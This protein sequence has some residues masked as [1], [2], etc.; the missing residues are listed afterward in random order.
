MT[1]IGKWKP[2]WSSR[3]DSKFSGNI[4]NIS[5]YTNSGEYIQEYPP[6]KKGEP[7]LKVTMKCQYYDGKVRHFMKGGIV[8]DFIY[9]IDGNDILTISNRRGDVWKLERV[10]NRTSK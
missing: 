2:F 6:L 4:D 5:E 1:I 7:P 10:V 8:A 3:P 9:D